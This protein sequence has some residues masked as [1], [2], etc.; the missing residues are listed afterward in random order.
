MCI[1][2][3]IFLPFLMDLAEILQNCRQIHYIYCVK[4]SCRNFPPFQRNSIFVWPSQMELSSEPQM[5]SEG[6]AI[7]QGISC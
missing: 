1:F 7:S 4:N 2:L 6:L 3:L 5:Y